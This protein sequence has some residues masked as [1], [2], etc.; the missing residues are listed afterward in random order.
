MTEITFKEYRHQ[1][2]LSILGGGGYVYKYLDL[3]KKYNK[4]EPS[5]K[6]IDFDRTAEIF[7]QNGIKIKKLK[8]WKMIE[9]DQVEIGEWVWTPSL[10]IKRGDGPDPMLKGINRSGTESVGD[11]W[12]NLA[13]D[14]AKLL[15]QSDAP[16]WEEI[17]MLKYDGTMECMER[18]VPDLIALFGEMKQIIR[19]GWS[20]QP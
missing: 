7:I 4:Y 15:N 6:G 13:T 20:N 14:A 10:V 5:L 18:M 3:C 16:T 2:L 9:F 12:R 17:R 1:K 8:R 19:H 11:T